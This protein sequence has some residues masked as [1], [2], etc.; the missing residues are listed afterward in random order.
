MCESDLRIQR[1][2]VL[3]VKYNFPFCSVRVI[4]L[5]GRDVLDDGFH[6]SQTSVVEVLIE[7]VDLSDF[8]WALGAPL[9]S[10]PR[11]ENCK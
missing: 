3:M 11:P 9:E 4:G 8:N 1:L 10:T 5:F 2:R 7:C 6:V